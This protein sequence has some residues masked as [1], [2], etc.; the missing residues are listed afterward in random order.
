MSHENFVTITFV[1]C[2]V[3]L[4]IVLLS[5]HIIYF[6][7]T[8]FYKSGT[9]TSSIRFRFCMLELCFSII[10]NHAA[11]QFTLSV[12]VQRI[13]CCVAH[14]VNMV[15]LFCW[16]SELSNGCSLFELYP[17]RG[18]LRGLLSNIE[19]TWYGPITWL[20]NGNVVN[21]IAIELRL[22][23]TRPIFFIRQIIFYMKK[24]YRY[25]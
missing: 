14:L 18:M 3:I 16:T 13:L 9:I 15:Y 12:L 23:K 24:S 11:F 19:K 10:D 1:L 6:F 5:N 20:Y 7:T 17:F 2:L 4:H 25:D 8:N 21:L 22:F